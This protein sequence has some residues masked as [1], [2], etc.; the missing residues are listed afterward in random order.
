MND[1]SIKKNEF[2]AKEFISLFTKRNNVL[3]VVILC[4]V[5]VIGAKTYWERLPSLI[6]GSQ[7][8][9]PLANTFIDTNYARS[10]LS[11][12]EKYNHSS[13]AIND[14]YL[15]TRVFNNYKIVYDKLDLD[16]SIYYKNS[17][18][19]KMSKYE[20]FYKKFTI[21]IPREGP[22]VPKGSLEL[23]FE[24]YHDSDNLDE[25]R[26]TEII[27][28]LNL[29]LQAG[30][31]AS[32]RNSKALEFSLSNLINQT[33]GKY[34]IILKTNLLYEKSKFGS[35]KN[36][37]S[38]NQSTAVIKLKQLLSD[39]KLNLKIARQLNFIKPSIDGLISIKPNDLKRNRMD[40]SYL[41]GQIYLEALEKSYQDQI[42]SYNA[43]NQE[44]LK[45]RKKYISNSIIEIEE[46]IK[47]NEN[48]TD[49]MDLE[50][51]FGLIDDTSTLQK[52]TKVFNNAMVRYNEI[53]SQIKILENLSNNQLPL[54]DY[55]I[56]NT[57][58]INKK[59]H[60]ATTM[61]LG[62]LVGIFLSATIVLSKK[63]FDPIKE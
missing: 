35:L 37:S 51:V 1:I 24:H 58:V 50:K 15:Q 55:E 20:N 29:Q 4:T 11:K 43:I 38:D 44:S 26:I 62:F 12:G 33:Q 22:T 42:D 8:I 63:F 57:Q 21:K 36:Q 5:S 7:M 6:S 40:D 48:L 13:E 60:K 59:R 28:Q 16:N 61:L 49:L 54:V 52:L 18:S 30:I 46:A 41:N 25:L 31:R 19:S 10:E 53:N 32:Y 45:D 17:T 56:M 23:N 27:Q 9:Y 34:E 39:T 47:I 2:T 14:Y 3:L